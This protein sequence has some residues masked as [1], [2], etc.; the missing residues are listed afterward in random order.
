MSIRGKTI[1]ATLAVMLIATAPAW[2]QSLLK[3]L[4]PDKD[5]TVSKDEYVGLVEKLFKEADADGEGTLD[6]KELRSK[7]G[8][9]L[10]KLLQ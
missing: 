6:P 9:Q 2:S 4:D 7:A 10:M 5:G 8:R 1:F 3:R